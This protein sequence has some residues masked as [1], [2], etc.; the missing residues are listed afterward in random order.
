MGSKPEKWDLEVDFVSIGSGLGG[1]T[2]AITAHDLGYEAVVLEKA[3]KLGGVSA[4]SGGE[5]WLPNNH[6]MKEDGILDS[7]EEGMKYF[8]FLSNGYGDKTMLKRMYEAAHQA[9]PYLEEEAGVKWRTIPD[10]PDYYYPR[11]PGTAAQGRYLE[12]EFF[13]GSELGEWQN[14]TY[15]SP[16]MP[17]GMTHEELLA[18]GGFTNLREWDF[19]K[20]AKNTADDL[21]GFGNG[22]MAYLVKASMIERSIPMF[23]NTK[24]CELIVEDERVVGLRAEREKNDFF[25]RAQR[26]VL[27]ATGGYDHDEAQARYWEDM[28]EWKTQVPPSVRGDNMILGGDVGAALAGVSPANLACM[29]GYHI[30]GEEHEGVALFRTSFEGGCP[31]AVWVNRAGNRFCDETFYK[32][33]QP[34]LRNYNGRA[35]DQ[36]NY[37]PF[38]ILDQNF[39]ER[40]AV[41]TFMPGDSIPEGFGHQADSLRELALMLGIDAKQLEATVKRYN[42]LVDKGKDT[43]FGR[44][45][46]PW[47]TKMMGDRNYPHPHMGHINKPPYFGIRLCTSSVGVNAVGLK[48]NINAQVMNVRGKAAH[49]LY[50]AGNSAA[51]IEIG[52]GYNSGIANTRGIAWGYIAARHALNGK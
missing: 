51:Q 9:L 14:K 13:E 20:M 35:M 12:V 47:A 43:D 22:L 30:P 26:G 32:D 23:L 7:D 48:T 8:A 50:A 27:I 16:I 4:Y 33:F 21:R 3:P 45:D 40:Y 31:H 37:P 38:L 34:A 52:P 28:P 42:K 1:L 15:L 6:K 19:E 39:R 44:G 49:G 17:L 10:F 18:W 5:V 46:Y 2:A 41:G 25:V 29:I 24:V 36:L 11:A